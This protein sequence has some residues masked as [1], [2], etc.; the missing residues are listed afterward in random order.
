M[1]PFPTRPRVAGPPSRRAPVFI[2]ATAL[3]AT[4]VGAIPAAAADPAGSAAKSAEPASTAA[5]ADAAATA[6]ADAKRT[7]K[8]V[9]VVAQRSEDEEVWANPNGTFTS[10]KSVLPTRV[11][12]DGKLVAVD[13]GLQKRK[14]GRIAPKATRTD[15]TFS[16][17]GDAPL[18]T[19]R[20]NGRDVVLTWPRP[21]PTPTMEGDTATYAEVIKGVDLRVTADAIGFSHQ[22][23]VKN[24]EAAADPALSSVTFGLKGNGLTVRK[25]ANGELRAVDPA[26]QTLFSSAQPQMWD[27]GATQQAPAGAAPVAKSMTASR[28]ASADK[29]ATPAP[30]ALSADPVPAVDGIALGTR[31]ADL[32][33]ELKGDKLTLTPDRKLLTAADTAFPVVIDP[34]WRDDWKSAWAIAYKH[35]GIA[36]SA[37]K[38]YWNGGTLSKEARVGCARDAQLGNSVVCAKTFFQVGMGALRGKQILGATLRIEQK[39]AGSWSCKSGDI[40]VWDTNSIDTTTTWNRQPAWKRLVDSSGQSYGGRNCPGDGNTVELNV[41]SAVADAARWGW[42]AWTL[43]LKSANDTVDVS[44]RKLNPDSVRI[45]T[46]YNTPPYP[47]NDRWSEPYVACEGGYMGTSDEVVLRAWVGDAENNGLQAEFHYWKADDYGTVKTPKVPVV[48][49]NAAMLRIPASELTG[50]SYRWDVR[51]VDDAGGTGPWAGQ[52]VFSIDRSRPGSLPGVTS[53]QFPSDDKPGAT[54][55]LARTEGTFTFD[56]GTDTDIT[57]YQWHTLTDPTVRTVDATGPGRTGTIKYT[58]LA[59][60]PHGLIV[61]S[62]DAAGNRSNAKAYRY[63]AKR[64]P[65]RDKHGDTNGD[66]ATDIWSVDPGDG[67]LWTVPGRGNGAFGEP[68]KVGKPGKDNFANATSLT[69]WGSWDGDF[70]EDLLVLRPVPGK[71]DRKNIYVYPGAGDSDLASSDSDRLELQVFD[72]AQRKWDR[73]DQVL[74]ISSIDDDDAN[75]KVDENDAPDLLV[76]AG[77]ELWLYTGTA[78]GELNVNGGPY[79]LGNAD[80]Q[81]M[82]LAAPGDLNGDGLPEIWARAK[83]TGKIHQY[84]SRKTTD[85]AAPLAIDLAVYA[86]PAV[87][88]GSIG[89]GFTGTAWPHLTSVGDFEKDGYPDLWSRDTSGVISEFQGR[90]LTNGSVF[91]PARQ[92]A[93]SGTPW[94]TCE[95]VPSAVSATAKHKLCGP[96]LAKFKAKG[97][98]A[99]FGKPSGNV[100]DT[101]DGG[102]FVHLRGNGLGADNASIYWHPSTGAWMVINGIREKWMSLGAEKGV[103]G[104][105]TSDEDKTFDEVGWFSTFAGP[106]GNGA[107]YW[108]PEFGAWATYGGIYEKYLKT[109]GP[110]GPLGYP[111]SD[112]TGHADGVGRYNTFRRSK[113]TSDTGSIHWT[114]Q[115]GAWSVRGTIRKKWLELGAEKSWLGYPKSD[116]YGIYGGPREDFQGGYIRHNSTTHV[117]VEHHFGDRTAD[118]RTELMGDFNGDGRADLATVYDHGNETTALYVQAAKADG[119]FGAPALAFNSGAWNFSYA[120]SQWVAGDF[121]GD[122]RDDL[123]ALYGYPG[124]SNGMFTFLGKADGTFTSLPRSA[125]TGAGNWEATKAKLTAGDYNG[126]GRDDVAF[127]YDHGGSTGAHTFLS[128][129]D[130]TFQHSFP[131]WRSAQGGWYWNESKQVSGDVNGDGRDDI[132]AMYG[133]G[134]GTVT[135]Y[136]LLGKSDGGFAA[137]VASWSRTPGNWDFGRSKITAGDYNADGRADLAVMF[138]YDNDRAALFTLTGKPD[139]GLNEDFQS[140]STP[141]GV[142]NSSLAGLPVSGDVDKDGRDDIAIMYDH[143]DGRSTTNTFLS[144]PDGGF[145]PPKPSWEAAPGTW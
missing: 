107:I 95:D 19:M 47:I 86:D 145:L 12:R 40:Q 42:P 125:Y 43:G 53:A 15:L 129:A 11:H 50:S 82:T 87:R 126:D 110:G 2:L 138:N 58:P 65:T 54:P 142:W 37:D 103:L 24:R 135:A 71:P 34:V 59:A 90:P 100:T 132:I 121:N 111:T 83:T 140:W 112:E 45:S 21:L 51:G 89:T 5:K 10:E 133:F 98:V 102:R 72:D 92:I 136:T 55:G 118:Q 61:W 94:T 114:P 13:T 106:S 17:G 48:S 26:G 85:T 38:S 7:G 122:G 116:E 32:G 41:T 56:P 66:G 31:Q 20:K 9:E 104:Y 123:A 4:L 115:T 128:N 93:S 80:W 52:C 67:Q 44:W 36:G 30:S 143:G 144:R 108:S 97:G 69:Q 141:E 27:S 3:V 70:Y 84:N 22:L 81:D 120:N 139:G 16:G 101:A 6:S 28:A 62:M 60:G 63:T 1:R 29:P 137:P 119:G 99:G 49:G 73:A 68:R 8:R 105:P 74:A 64:Q 79:L 130:G 131:S 88:A 35:N 39:S 77:T 113:E 23:V 46:E 33:V 109:G 57:R 78:T 134:N 124:G 96:I 117:S 25:E 14:D 75:G 18:V 91:G 76:K 127:F